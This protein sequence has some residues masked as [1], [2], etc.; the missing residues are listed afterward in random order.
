MISRS[1]QRMDLLDLA[2][3]ADGGKGIRLTRETVSYSATKMY[4]S[5]E[6]RPRM[7]HAS[8]SVLSESRVKNEGKSASASTF[9]YSSTQTVTLSHMPWVT[10]PIRVYA[11][12]P[13]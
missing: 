5:L 13:G 12:H 8:Q 7:V 4:R 1:E 9:S 11:S 3:S 10:S 2:H 6:Q